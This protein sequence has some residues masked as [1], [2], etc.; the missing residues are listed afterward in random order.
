[1]GQI[2]S[3]HRV[4]SRYGGLKKWELKWNTSFRA[5]HVSR[6]PGDRV[7]SLLPFLSDAYNRWPNDGSADMNQ[8]RA[9]QPSLLWCLGQAH[10]LGFS[11]KVFKPP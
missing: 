3:E 6:H 4:D 8:V 2:A 9:L 5:D 1:M 10:K 7:E 11:E